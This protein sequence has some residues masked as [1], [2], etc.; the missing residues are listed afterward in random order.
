MIFIFF[1]RWSF[2]AL[3]LS[4]K[5]RLLS[6][7]VWGST[8]NACT[9]DTHLCAWLC[10]CLYAHVYMRICV[11]ICVCKCV[12]VCWVLWSKT[13]VLMFVRQTLPDELSPQPS[14]KNNVLFFVC[15]NPEFCS[16]LQKWWGQFIHFNSVI[17]AWCGKLW[18]RGSRI[19][20]WCHSNGSR[21]GLWFS[22][23]I[24]T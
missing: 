12:C 15:L 9:I 20:G 6:H 11:Y 13:Q 3:V 19:W 22:S 4:E 21:L 14:N 10:I 18:Q 2:I 7:W 23:L 17:G 8:S 24:N 16:W 5:V 1:L